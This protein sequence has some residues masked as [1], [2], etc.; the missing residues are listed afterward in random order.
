MMGIWA[1]SSIILQGQTAFL[2]SG[3]TFPLSLCPGMLVCGQ[4]LLPSLGLA[5]GSLGSM[6][7]EGEEPELHL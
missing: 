1:A 6:L 3:F 4:A 2:V 7:G 5:V